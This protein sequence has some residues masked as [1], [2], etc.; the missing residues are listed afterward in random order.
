MVFGFVSKI[1]L[2]PFTS[3]IIVFLVAL[4][5]IV[6]NI[7][8]VK[9]LLRS[10]T[11]SRLYLSLVLLFGCLLITFFHSVTITHNNSYGYFEPTEV[12]TIV[13]SIIVVGIW[14]GLTFD[15]FERFA[16][17]LVVVGIIQSLSV[18]ASAI[19]PAFQSFIVDH[20]LYEG[21]VDKVGEAK[22]DD[23]ARSPGIGIA[24][25]SGSLILAYCCF[26]LV[27]LKIENRINMLLFGVIFSLITGATAFVGRSG[28]IVELA[29]LLYYGFSSGKVKTIF[30]LLV[31]AIIGLFIFDQ[32]MSQLDPMVAEA[33]QSWMFGFLDMDKVGNTN[34]GIIKGGFPKF[35]GKFIFGTGVAFGQHN[36][37][38]F[39]ADSG[40]IKS[41]TSIGIIGM[42][43]YY[44]GILCLLIS[45]F[46]KY[47]PKKRKL[48][49]WVAIA[50]IYMMEYKEPFIGMFVYPWVIF[51]MGLLWNK[52][53]K[54]ALYENS[55]SGRL[56]A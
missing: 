27:G 35:S 7:G 21:Y 10:L 28:L 32:V 55:Y 18:F 30:A 19:N 34:E 46:P 15:S 26:A 22:L 11:K 44:I 12:I 2:G 41:Y 6:F 39:Y 50:A 37:Q 14:A 3:F 25:S 47:F 49:L 53:Q 17:I 16:W 36:G 45:T 51:V 5:V 20:F 33:T 4:M 48:F 29:L 56:R 42:I 52:E 8:K 23:L 38:S 1:R 13:T 31:V 40:Y 9:R 43:C 24:W 54:Q